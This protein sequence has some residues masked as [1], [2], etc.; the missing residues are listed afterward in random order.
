MW[1]FSIG[2][3]ERARCMTNH[4]V[5]AKLY[6]FPQ[7]DLGCMRFRA[8][9]IFLLTSLPDNFN[10]APAN[11]S[12]GSLM[13]WIR[14][15]LQTYSARA[16]IPAC[17]IAKQRLIESRFDAAEFF[18][19][20]LLEIE[21]TLWFEFF[22]FRRCEVYLTSA[23]ALLAVMQGISCTTMQKWSRRFGLSSL[24]RPAIFSMSLCAFFELGLVCFLD[25]FVQ[26]APWR[27]YGIF[28]YSPC[29]CLRSGAWK[30]LMHSLYLLIR[31]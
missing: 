17:H 14:K 19:P 30:F 13:R 18:R 9:G 2:R 4:G 23:C 27:W 6:V 25:A 10:A 29:S 11:F 22:S 7:D 15:I 5:E 21:K 12:Q 31:L 20:Y 24:C 28:H 16:R 3:L 26:S 1:D 8:I